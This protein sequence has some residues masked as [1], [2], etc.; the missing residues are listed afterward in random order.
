M[1][2]HTAFWVRKELT[3]GRFAGIVAVR[4]E[5]RTERAK[6][7]EA[8]ERARLEDTAIR[9][10]STVLATFIEVLGLSADGSSKIMAAQPPFSV[11][12]LLSFG[13]LDQQ[14]MTA[15][16]GHP[17]NLGRPSNKGVAIGA[18]VLSDWKR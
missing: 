5:G 6:E 15:F 13:Q 1:A 9:T 4:L 2:P 8:R 12:E 3:Q 10:H 7:L 18:L 17:N 16:M 11:R 14:R